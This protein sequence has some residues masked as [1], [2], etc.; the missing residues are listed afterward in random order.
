MDDVV[1]GMFLIVSLVILCMAA[2]DA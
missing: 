2:I 1:A